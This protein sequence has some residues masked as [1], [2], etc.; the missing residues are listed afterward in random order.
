MNKILIEAELPSELAAQASAF[1]ADGWA[2]DLNELL[3]EALRRFLESHEGSL[4]E[5]FVR[6]DVEWGLHGRD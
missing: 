2:T 5:S 1:V 3:A 4:T 6:D